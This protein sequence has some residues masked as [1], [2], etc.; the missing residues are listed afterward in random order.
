MDDLYS[1]A[2]T[3]AGDIPM[4]ERI[5]AEVSFVKELERTLGTP[6]EVVRVYRAWTEVMESESAVLHIESAERAYLWPKAAE[7]ANRAGFRGLGDLGEAHFEMR[8][9]RSPASA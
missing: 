2:L 9:N 4:A 3:D 6:D 1:V 5:A 7:A 8:L